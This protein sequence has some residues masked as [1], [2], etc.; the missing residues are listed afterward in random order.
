MCCHWALQRASSCLPLSN[1]WRLSK[2][3]IKLSSLRIL[4]N[5]PACV[6]GFYKTGM[7][8][9]S[10]ALVHIEAREAVCPL[11]PVQ[12]PTGPEEPLTRACIVLRGHRWQK[13][14]ASLSTAHGKHLH[15]QH[16]PL[17]VVHGSVAR[18][19]FRSRS[20]YCFVNHLSIRPPGVQRKI[21]RRKPSCCLCSVSKMWKF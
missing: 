8:W 5:V 19:G 6:L 12:Q 3:K 9:T 20:P 18:V 1:F 17:K 7:L 21:Q 15:L 16:S 14:L 2:S 10:L 13:V 11:L 4:T